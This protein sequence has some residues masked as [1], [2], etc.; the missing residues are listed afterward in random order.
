MRTGFGRRSSLSRKGSRKDAEDAP[1]RVARR[2]LEIVQ[3][4]DDQALVQGSLD[5]GELVIVNGTHRIVPGQQVT[6]I[7]VSNEFKAPFQPETAE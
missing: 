7:N 4:E 3:L 2:I 1:L 6:T 5:V